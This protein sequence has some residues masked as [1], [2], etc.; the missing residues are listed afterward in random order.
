[1]S[2]DFV[3]IVSHG[4]AARMIMQTNL[5]GILA[6]R[7]KGVGIISPDAGD[8]NLK[9]LAV[10]NNIK[11]FQF[12]P[13]LSSV[14]SLYIRS[15]MYLFE[16]IKGNPA[17][18]EKY[19]RSKINS[20]GS[21]IHR[22]HLKTLKIIHDIKEQIPFLK[23]LF[24]KAD[25]FFLQ[26]QEAEIL[27]AKIGPRN[28]ISTYPVNFNEGRLLH[29][30]NKMGI[31]TTI[32]LLSWDNITCKGRFPALANDYLVWGEVMKEELCE[33]YEID[34]HK[35]KIVGVPHFDVH[36][37]TRSK[38]AA[39]HYLE[40]LGLDP[41]KPFLFFGMSSPRFAPK[42]IEIVEWI[43]NKIENDGY[44][45]DMQFV[46]RPHPQNVQG[47]MS[48]SSWLTRLRAL[49]GARVGVD[50]PKLHESNLKWSIDPEDM[51][52]LSNLLASCSICLNSGSTISLDALVAGVPVILTSFD[53]G[54]DLHYWDSSE[55]LISYTH[56]RKLVDFGGVS[57][58]RDYLEL[59]TEIRDYLRMPGR[60][61][62]EREL[63]VSKECGLVRSKSS[64][65]EIVS[66]LLNEEV[67]D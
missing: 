40:E 46:I 30:A 17:L 62:V 51:Y 45:S 20:S 53:G 65:D 8:P 66:V 19:H 54:H 9:R 3:Y 13:K 60:R 64:T 12:D 23:K 25:H 29:A 37:I 61:S 28:L 42:E 38:P 31:H 18:F 15:R 63:T 5:L 1:M 32:H 22:V 59:D 7:G 39:Q 33:F 34:N 35:I 44:C 58:C 26:S 24:V 41:K 10:E 36:Q 2:L 6:K 16:N 67:L 50:F 47:S 21:V 56:L 49:A 11:L 14:A 48:D 43:A 55:R 57:V 27:L 52:K 4:F